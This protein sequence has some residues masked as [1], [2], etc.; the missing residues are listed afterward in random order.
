M[1][2]T[3]GGECLDVIGTVNYRIERYLNFTCEWDESCC[4][5]HPEKS[6]YKSSASDKDWNISQV[7]REE[8]LAFE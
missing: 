4:K 8:E 6:S 2:Y 1:Y 5:T 7:E 3:E